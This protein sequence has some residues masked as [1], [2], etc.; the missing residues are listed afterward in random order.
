MQKKRK[1]IKKQSPCSHLCEQ[2]DCF[3][4]CLCFDPYCLTV[5]Q[6]IFTEN[7]VEKHAKLSRRYI[8]T[9]SGDN[10]SIRRLPGKDKR[11]PADGKISS[12]RQPYF[13]LFLV[14]DHCVYCRSFISSSISS[15]VCEFV[16]EGLMDEGSS[17]V[18]NTK[19]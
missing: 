7:R 16:D 9:A 2:G 14:Y 1:R 15:Y 6:D 19:K 11:L 3:T 10:P 8:L 17:L 18:P 4:L 12:V 13:C 5:S